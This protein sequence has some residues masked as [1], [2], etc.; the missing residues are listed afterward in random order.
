MAKC[1]L[2][3]WSEAPNLSDIAP[4][5]FVGSGAGQL[6]SQSLTARYFALQTDTLC[7]LGVALVAACRGPLTTFPAILFLPP[8]ADQ[9]E[10]R[11]AYSGWSYGCRSP[12]VRP[13]R[14]ATTCQR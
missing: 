5:W 1:V 4:K 3:V 8:K 9:L 11:E 14:A 7:N 10:L 12:Q 6:A 2:T 13:A